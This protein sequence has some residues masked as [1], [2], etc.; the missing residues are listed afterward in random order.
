MARVDYK[1]NGTLKARIL[2]RLGRTEGVVSINEE[3]WDDGFCETCSFPESGFSV[4]VDGEI[5]WPSREYLDEFGG[6]YD[7]DRDGYV[8]GKKLSSFGQFDAWLNSRPW[9]DEE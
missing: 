9:E 1:I 8:S 7:A 3:H 5:V 6:R 4:L 2:A